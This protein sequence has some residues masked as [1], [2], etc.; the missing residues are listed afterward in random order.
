MEKRLGGIERGFTLIELVMVMA[1][2]GI[3]A[4]IAMPKF[5][6]V[7]GQ[8]RATLI[9]QAAN[10]AGSAANVVHG[11]SL[12]KAGVADA[13]ACPGTAVTA[14][15]SAGAAG[16]LCAEAGVVSMVFGYPAAVATAGLGAGNPG[17]V[18]AMGISQ[19]F[20]PTTATLAAAGW[21]VTGVG[22]VQTFQLSGAPTPANCSFTYTQPTAAGVQGLVSA[23]I[24]TGC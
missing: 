10:N 16:T 9:K 1:I 3:L 13:A 7:A 12:V 11:A 21:T 15:N 2:V 19:Q 20:N 8:A 23:P 17:I 4:A 14:N 6:N 22:N 5:V 18:G 24:T